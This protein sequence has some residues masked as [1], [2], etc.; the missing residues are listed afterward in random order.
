MY[1]FFKIAKEGKMAL[2]DSQ[3]RVYLDQINQVRKKI[4]NINQE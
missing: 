2:S 1:D 3:K 4:E